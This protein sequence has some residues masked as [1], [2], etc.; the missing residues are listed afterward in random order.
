MINFVELKFEIMKKGNTYYKKYYYKHYVCKTG[1]T[2]LLSEK[3]T[4]N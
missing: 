2:V 3:E 4:D 1:N